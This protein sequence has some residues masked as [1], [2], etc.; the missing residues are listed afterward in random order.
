M[1]SST[2]TRSARSLRPAIRAPTLHLRGTRNVSTL[3]ENPQIVPTPIPFQQTS[4]KL[5]R[6][7]VHPQ[8]PSRPHKIPPFAPPNNPP[9]APARC[10]NRLLAPRNSA[11]LRLKPPIPPPPIRSLRRTR[12]L[13]LHGPRPSRRLRLAGRL[14]PVAPERRRG[15]RE[16]P[17]W[18]WRREYG[19]VDSC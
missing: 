15:G 17:G 2:F 3:P 6:S 16:S 13:R 8:R 9:N 1:L 4:S 5:T 14:Q 10:R 11:K 19:W 12:T 7:P 18:C